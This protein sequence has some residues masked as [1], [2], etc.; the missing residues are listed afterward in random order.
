M[1]KPLIHK[2][3]IKT[4][5][6]IIIITSIMLSAPFGDAAQKIKIAS[7]F[8]KTGPGVTASRT[9][10]NG[11]RFAVEE[12]NQQ[13]GLLGKQIEIVELDNKSTALSSRLAAKKA[14][15]AGVIAVFGAIWSS[16]SLAMASVLQKAKIPMISPF[17][18][19]PRVTLVGDYIFRICFIDSFQGK[20][21]ANFAFNDLKAKTA[22]IIVNADSRYSE[23]LADFFKQQFKRKGG[24]I[25]FEASYLQ[26]TDNFSS[27][28]KKIKP[29][30]PDVIFLPG[31]NKDSAQIIRQ[32]HDK[33]IFAPFLG[34]DSWGTDMYHVAGSALHGNFYSGHW[35]R[36][37]KNKKSRQFVKKYERRFGILGSTGPA[38]AYDTVFIFADAVR[39]AGSLNPS[40]IRDVLAA[41]RNFKG[42]TGNISFDKN[43]DPVKPAVIRKF[44]NKTSVY[45]KTVMP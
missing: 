3:S 38:L 33:K 30:N 15:K 17:S 4:L 32:A 25:L 27:T 14:V 43:G 44:D 11:I 8:S 12:L 21:M 42:V 24:E 41:T 18:T 40:K 2:L 31:H 26:N 5:F 23:G 45:V 9:T 29:F 39:R 16:N 7:I 6:S 35:H 13:G 20:A 28:I 34:G 19:N 10:L 22:A 36:D 37:S 1:L